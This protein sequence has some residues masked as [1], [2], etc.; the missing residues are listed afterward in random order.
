[1]ESDFLKAKELFNYY[2]GNKY[3]MARDA[4]L[5]EY[6]S[7]HISEETELNW[8]EELFYEK[9]NQL[10]AN[11]CD[12]FISMATFIHMHPRLLMSKLNLLENIIKLNSNNFI[13]KKQIKILFETILEELYK[14]KDFIKSDDIA[15]F[16]KLKE[17]L[18]VGVKH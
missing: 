6:L 1:M 4:M 11:N 10:S 9:Y 15:R 3:F 18:V 7:Y 2:G 14:N 13:C 17:H 12:N 16:E 8:I 5:N